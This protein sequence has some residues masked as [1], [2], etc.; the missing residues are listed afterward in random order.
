M[1]RHR[2]LTRRVGA[3][4]SRA[5]M[6]FEIMLWGAMDFKNAIKSP[7]VLLA[8]SHS[9]VLRTRKPKILRQSSSA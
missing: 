7:N 5:K 8:L 9:Q 1:R 2:L 4:E 6:K 3:T